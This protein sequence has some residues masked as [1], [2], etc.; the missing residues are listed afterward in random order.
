[1]DTEGGTKRRKD[2]AA[3]NNLGR[4][5]ELISD[6]AQQG[7]S[8]CWSEKAG[9]ATYEMISQDK[10]DLSEALHDA[11]V[12]HDDWRVDSYTISSCDAGAKRPDGLIAKATTH[13]LKA[14]L[15]KRHG[16]SAETM[17]Q[18]VIE[19]I[20]VASKAPAAV[21]ATRN[22]SASTKRMTR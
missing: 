15:T 19:E 17:R 8:A 6:A 11:G 1:M 3:A 13:H 10:V 4:A 18:K 12:T 14:Q 2:S 7:N 16:Y 22:L 20:K 5:A 21:S 9:K